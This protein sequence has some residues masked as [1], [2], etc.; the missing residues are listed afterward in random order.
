MRFL[1]VT[2]KAEAELLQAKTQAQYN[3][4]GSA[5]CELQRKYTLS[6]NNLFKSILKSKDKNIREQVLRFLAASVVSNTARAKL[7]HN[8]M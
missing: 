8:L 5:L 3:K 6:L 2:E 7:G 1:K 4:I